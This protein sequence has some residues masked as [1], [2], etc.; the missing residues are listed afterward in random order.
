MFHQGVACVG[1]HLHS[2]VVRVVD[3]EK[4]ADKIDTPQ[5]P[6]GR[7]VVIIPDVAASRVRPARVADEPG[8][9]EVSPATRTCY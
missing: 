3:M 5:F 8:T 2:H 7:D 4:V 1:E 6:N 9:K